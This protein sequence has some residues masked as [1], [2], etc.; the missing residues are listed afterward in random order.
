MKKFYFARCNLYIYTIIIKLIMNK[1]LTDIFLSDFGHISFFENVAFSTE[2]V[3]DR[4]C[5]NRYE[6]CQIN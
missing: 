5:T 3:I 1:S 4:I 6:N 2:P